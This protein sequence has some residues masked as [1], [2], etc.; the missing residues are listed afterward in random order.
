LQELSTMILVSISQGPI[1][2]SPSHDLLQVGANQ[3][4]N[5]AC[6][7]QFQGSKEFGGF[8]RKFWD[9]RKSDQDSMVP[10]SIFISFVWFQLR[11]LWFVYM[12][13]SIVDPN[14]EVQMCL[15]TSSDSNNKQFMLLDKLVGF[16]CLSALLGVGTHRLRKGM[17]SAP[18]LRHGTRPYMSRPG[19]WSVDGFLRMAY[20]SVAETMPDELL[21]IDSINVLTS[22]C[23]SL[24]KRDTTVCKSISQS[25]T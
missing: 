24:T 22:Q 25:T 21:R 2:S 7:K 9:M 1:V 10:G 20:D 8:L 13:T 17:A 12:K 16:K 6:Y 4:A 11:F 23:K 15:A 18:D 5:Q 3:G 19:T 14:S